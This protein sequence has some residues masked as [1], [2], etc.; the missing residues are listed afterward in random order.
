MVKTEK[1]KPTKQCHICQVRLP[2][3][4]FIAIINVPINVRITTMNTNVIPILNEY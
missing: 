1:N 2:L 3:F 4:F